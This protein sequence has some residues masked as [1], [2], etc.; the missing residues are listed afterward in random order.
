MPE[1]KYDTS[2]HAGATA[3]ERIKSRLR[4][5]GGEGKSTETHPV[6]TVHHIHH[7][8]QQHSGPLYGSGGD[9]IKPVGKGQR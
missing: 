4:S 3:E 8:G 6:R 7:G 9:I 5:S 1:I 2:H